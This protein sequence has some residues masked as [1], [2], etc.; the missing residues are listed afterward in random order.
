MNNSWECNCVQKWKNIIEP[1]RLICILNYLQNTVDLITRQNWGQPLWKLD[2]RNVVNDKSPTQRCL[3]R[4]RLRSPLIYSV[5]LRL[6][7]SKGS[8]LGQNSVIFDV[9]HELGPGF[10]RTRP[11][12]LLIQNTISGN[13]S[14]ES[15][16]LTPTLSGLDI[17]YAVV[18]A[19][20]RPY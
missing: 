1:R 3:E 20:T 4:S 8:R 2:F 19:V 10:F 6:D 11:Y 14:F 5:A 12:F 9:N 7:T 16:S 17:V 15:A 13:F 18:I